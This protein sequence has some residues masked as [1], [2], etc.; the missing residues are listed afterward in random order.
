MW[1][2]Q[3]SQSDGGDVAAIVARAKKVGLTHIYVRTGSS[4][5]GFN[6]GPFL[7]QILPAAHAAGLRV[8]G[9]DFPNFASWQA[10]VSR[11]V[12]AIRFTAPGGQHLD[13]F[14]ADVETIHEGTHITAQVADTYGGNL[15]KAVGWSYPLI[16]AVPRPSPDRVR[17][18]PYADAI[19]WFDAVAP[20][21][22]WLNREPGSDTAGAMSYLAQFQ[23]KILPIGQAYDGGPEGGRPG[24]PPPAELLRFMAVAQQYGAPAISF[25]SWQA[26]DQRAWD[27]IR[28]APEYRPPAP[29]TPPA[30]K[31]P[32]RPAAATKPAAPKPAAST[33]AA[34]TAKPSLAALIAKAPMAI[35][36]RFDLDGPIN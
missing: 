1:I 6:G 19:R 32:A 21:V 9:W 26:A 7:A 3:P 33:P 36:L 8:I 10:D 12:A 20:M 14:A 2:W 24:V 22:Y 35:R 5:D 15:R 25:W 29:R 27:A 11:A 28:D 23:R 30:P 18:Y 4:W 31:R 16:V 34:S 13:G 17:D